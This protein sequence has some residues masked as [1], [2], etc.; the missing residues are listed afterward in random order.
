MLRFRAFYRHPT[1]I[2]IQ[3]KLY[4]VLFAR[5]SYYTYTRKQLSDKPTY[6]KI[7]REKINIKNGEY[8][9]FVAAGILTASKKMRSKN[10]TYA[11]I[12]FFHSAKIEISASY[13]HNTRFCVHENTRRTKF[14]NVRRERKKYHRTF[15]HFNSNSLISTLPKPEHP[16]NKVNVQTA[17]AP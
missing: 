5:T 14:I 4:I 17:K 7:A 8:I 3:R 6:L 16:I 1:K 15:F 10:Y 12:R 2:P 13:T 9:C 11:D